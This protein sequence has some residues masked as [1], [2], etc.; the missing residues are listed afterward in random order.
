VEV[1]VTRWD[2][3]LL[4]DLLSVGGALLV[5]FSWIATNVVG[6]RLKKAK[7]AYDEG[8]KNRRLFATLNELTQAIESVAGEA[9]AIRR[10]LIENA[11]EANTH[12]SSGSACSRRHHDLV[13][14]DTASRALNARQLDWGL[15]FCEIALE[16][17]AADSVDSAARDKLIKTRERICQLRDEKNQLIH[18]MRQIYAAEREV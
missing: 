2:L 17:S 10:M 5:F 6:E 18:E 16:E 13:M 3:G 12:L 7:T 4:G 15:K 8:R 1:Q 9:I 11:L 14:L